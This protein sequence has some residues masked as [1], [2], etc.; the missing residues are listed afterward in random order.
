MVEQ[1]LQQ[2]V[3]LQNCRSENKIFRHEIIF[4]VKPINLDSNIRVAGVA[5]F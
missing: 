1:N 3:K 4:A 2:V 5:A